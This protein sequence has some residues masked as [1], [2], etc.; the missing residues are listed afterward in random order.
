MC[1]TRREA[2]EI[3]DAQKGRNVGVQVGYMRR[4]APAFL[5]ACDAVKQR[6]DIKFAR[7][8]DFLGFN[9]L[10]VNATS[11]V[12][13][14]EQLPEAVKKDA[15]AREDALLMEALGGKPAE[16]LGKAY[17]L[18][19]GLSSHGLSAMRELLGMPHK[20]LFAAQR[21]GG[22]Y[23]GGDLRLRPLRVPIRNQHRP[24][25]AFRRAPGGVR[26]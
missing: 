16:V 25:R 13:R 8:R 15:K 3:M 14:D 24:P 4:Y 20:V 21:G 23:L 1:I 6:G 2:E 26:R 19:L 7:V 12:V 9:S 18:M 11:R 22:L 17:T 5:E 10:I